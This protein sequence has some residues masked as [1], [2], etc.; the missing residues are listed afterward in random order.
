MLGGQEML[1]RVIMAL[2][3]KHCPQQGAP[4]SPVLVKRRAAPG[5]KTSGQAARP[6]PASRRA[7]VA[8]RQVPVLHE[9]RCTGQT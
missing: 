4:A 1:G 9:T 2:S 7:V 3:H 8:K 6:A 5:Q